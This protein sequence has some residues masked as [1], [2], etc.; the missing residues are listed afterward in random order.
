MNIALR[1]DRDMPSKSAVSRV[2]MSV[3][4]PFAEESIA[5]VCKTSRFAA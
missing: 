1:F 5:L 3:S 2:T 4:S